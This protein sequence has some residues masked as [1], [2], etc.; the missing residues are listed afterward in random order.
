MDK[1]EK[2]RK[3]EGGEIKIDYE[4]IDVA[5]IMN[6][7][8]KKIARRPKGARKEFRKEDIPAKTIPASLE[9][10]E[11]SGAKAKMKRILLKL[12]KP[13][14]PLIKLLIFPVYAQFRE[15]VLILDQT[16]RRLDFLSASID[17]VDQRLKRAMEYT[18][19]L[20]SL[21]HNIVVE[22]TKLKIEEENLRLKTRIM[23][24]DFESLGK[25][26]GALEKQ[27]LK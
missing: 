24:K 9:Q 19:L 18:K 17:E 15:T 4:N 13:F 2:G 16:N 5:D 26:E 8:K 10:Y 7:I 21:S 27:V 12:T 25:R 20:H 3:F 1:E 22:L 11:A 6:Q 14:S 23:E